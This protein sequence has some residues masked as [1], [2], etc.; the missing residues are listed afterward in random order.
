MSQQPHFSSR[1]GMMLAMLGMAVGTGNIWRFPRIAAQ[2][3]GGE[4][5]VT[6]VVF[7][8]LWSIPLVLVEF[9]IGRKLRCGPIKAFMGLMG[10]RWAW[11]GAFVVFITMAIM[12]YYSVVAGWTFRFAAAAITGQVPE[13]NPGEFWTRYSTSW[14]P[15]LTHGMA[16][17][18]ATFVVARG[19]NFIERVAK[20]LMPTLLIL[21]VLLTVRAVT[22]PGAGDG[23]AY[24]FGVDWSQLANA[25]LWIEG[26]TQNAWDTGAGW[27]L[28]LCYA[29]YLPPRE[30]TVQNA[31]ILPTV[32]NMIS[33]TAG[34][35]VM[36]TVFSVVP[37]LVA[38]LQSNP[39]ALA[40]YPSLV[41]AI[42]SGAELT[43]ELMRTTIFSQS[44]EGLTFVWMP[45]LFATMPFGRLFMSL[46]FLALAF[47]AIT[48]LIAMVELG[49]RALVDLGVTRGRAVQVVGSVG[50]L[51][52]LPSVASLAFLRNQDWVWGVGLMVSG[53]FFAIAIITYGVKR[54]REEQL[55]HADS[56]WRVGRWWDIVIG[57]L[58]P[59]QAVVLLIWWLYQ[60]RGWDPS[61]LA[62]FQ[63]ANV[64]TVLFQ[65]AV[66]LA[67]V[68]VFNR[69][70][71]TRVRGAS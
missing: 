37:G 3:G 8:F 31:F 36:C 58:V 63:E 27:G 2:N 20:I 45:Q 61:W 9:G 67:G 16:I 24:L 21:V 51:L 1:L 15:A 25:R 57:V 59:V 19:V 47:A 50:F 28:V 42:E 52:G 17:G 29:A 69:W 11:M 66:A 65:W 34:V 40:A 32:N 68:I 18:L 26:L 10:P 60:A 44:N 33:L 49:T 6:W 30:D 55:N 70:I 62:P 23:L 39:E 5:L 43:P 56:K 46:F 7:L 35:M 38:N 41:Q 71:V 13:A 4:F 12:F 54:F 22:L 64:G 53:L 14:W 48:S